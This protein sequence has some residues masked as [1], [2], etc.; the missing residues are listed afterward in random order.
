MHFHFPVSLGTQ[1]RKLNKKFDHFKHANAIWAKISML[2]GESS[3]VNFL[4]K[5]KAT[6]TTTL[7]F[8]MKNCFKTIVQCT[9]KSLPL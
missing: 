9:V 4:G 8:P 2:I 5:F 3:S 7:M 1:F 6:H